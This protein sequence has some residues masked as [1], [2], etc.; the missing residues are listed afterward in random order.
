MASSVDPVLAKHYILINLSYLLSGIF[1]TKYE[2]QER[3]SL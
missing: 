2:T 3:A 1:P